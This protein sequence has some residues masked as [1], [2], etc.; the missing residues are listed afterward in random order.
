MFELT[1]SGRGRHLLRNYNPFRELEEFEKNFWNGDLLT[2]FKTDIKDNGDSYLLE[3]DLPGFKKE[4]IKIDI[5][6]DSLTICGERHSAAEEKDNRGNY[7]R[8]E[9]SYGS[10]SRSFN[11]SSVKTDEIRANY[12]NGVLR[13]T[14][15][16]KEETKPTVKQLQIE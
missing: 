10:F 5:D 2:E 3:A 4:D 11:V 15:P 8:C 6:N 9:R 14:M 7:V 1:P 16:K 12:E 13:L